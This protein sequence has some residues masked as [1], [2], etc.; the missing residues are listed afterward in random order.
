MGKDAGSSE[1]VLILCDGW[2]RT[3][4]L[5]WRLVQASEGREGRVAPAPQ[6]PSAEAYQPP[7]DVERGTS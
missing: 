6:A 7:D 2:A 4:G 3:I 5:A 1:R